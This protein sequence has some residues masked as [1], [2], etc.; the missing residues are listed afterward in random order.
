MDMVGQ[1]AAGWLGRP[2]RFRG[3]GQRG[4]GHRVSIEERRVRQHIGFKSYHL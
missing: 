3:S 1:C 4:R 2:Q